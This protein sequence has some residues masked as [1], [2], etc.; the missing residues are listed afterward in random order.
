MRILSLAVAL[1]ASTTA[2]AAPVVLT[3]IEA[4]PGRISANLLTNPGF[5]AERPGGMAAG[6]EWDA[7][8]TTAVGALDRHVRHGGT[9]SFRITNRTPFGAHVYG[10]L[11]ASAPVRLQPGKPYTASAWVRSAD[12]GAAHLMGGSGWQFRAALIKTGGEWR[13]IATTFTPSES[14]ADFV[15]RVSTESPSDGFWIDDLKLEEGAA[16]TLALV[17]GPSAAIQAAAVE[18]E[19]TIERDGPFDVDFDLSLPSR[20]RLTLSAELPGA[21]AP[22]RRT[23]EMESGAWI[24]RIGGLAQSADPGP[25]I[26]RLSVQPAGGPLATSVAAVRFH[27]PTAARDRAKAVQLALPGLAAQV[28]RLRAAGLDTSYA[29]VD[30]QILREFVGY[31]SRDIEI[32]Q[33]KRALEELDEMAAVQSRLVATVADRRALHRVPRWTGAERPTL[34][35]GS[36]VA[37]TR[38]PGDKVETKRPIFFT[39][40]GHFGRVVTDLPKWSALGCNIIQVEFGPSSVLTGPES[41]SMAAVEQFRHVLDLARQ[42]GVAV[43]LLIS[44]HY[45]PDWAYAAYPGLRARTAGFLPYCL[46]NADGTALLKRFIRTALPSLADHPALQ[47]ICLSNEPVSK[48][49]PCAAGTVMWHRWLTDRHGS[50]ATLNARWGTALTAVDDAPLPD[51][52]GPRPAPAAWADYI[53]FNQ[54]FFAGWHKQLA[55]TVHEV[56]PKL[57][58]HAKT[59]NWTLLGDQEVV[60]GLDAYLFSKLSQINGNDAVNNYT[61][62]GSDMAQNWEQNAMGHDLQR[63]CLEAP[64]FNS[65]NHIIADRDTRPVP[66]EH[67]AAALWQAA[68]HGQ[69]ATTI[70]VWERTEDP[71][72]DFAASIMHRPA[73][74]A[75]VGHVGLDLMRLAPEVTAIQRSKPDLLLLQSVSTLTWNGGQHTDCLSK[76]YSGLTMRGLK[77]GFITERQL[78]EGRSAAG[79]T[80][81]LCAVTHLSDKARASLT[82]SRA[83]LVA[84]GDGN[85]AHNE[86][87]A[88]REPIAATLAY[89]HAAD[90][91][92]TVWERLGGLMA[93]RNLRPAASVV[94][95][96]GS[97]QYGVAWRCAVDG[98]TVLVNV[99]NYNHKPV[100][101]RVSAGSGPCRVSDLI[102]DRPGTGLI[103]L[104]PLQYR[105]LRLT[106]ARAAVR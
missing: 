2:C 77:V 67:T 92:R 79:Q 46:H 65:E 41:V 10:M 22:V 44:P 45:M 27:S 35:A 28:D 31:V 58:V 78:E 61:F 39:G 29:A 47:S 17:D 30:L 18:N 89:R 90:G 91:R 25:K 71:R 62:G 69:G 34:E 59:M 101:L 38:T 95:A 105:L 14:D 56:A 66:P 48:E 96:D 86:Y 16:A 106:P 21:G 83:R 3:S 11:W 70:W 64:I 104:K 82:D 50:V 4:R 43:C 32:G 81:L 84:V 26:V 57:P 49:P 98:K 74:A 1:A 13:R 7:R 15:L 9:T 94:A 37:S 19:R 72:S 76:V 100:T 87:G 24:V 5:E 55:D 54:E 52:F 99:I 85:L 51:P 102:A 12:P 75:I 8:N 93:G 33:T 36:F 73:S 63:S 68:I 40:F 97:E 6:W 53:R 60:Y 103:T 80:V 23:M 42:N 20:A 88:G